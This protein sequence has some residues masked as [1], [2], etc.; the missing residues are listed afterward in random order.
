M[1]FVGWVFDT[2]SIADYTTYLLKNTKA[3]R[4][5]RGTRIAIRRA[6]QSEKGE[7]ESAI[8]QQKIEIQMP[9]STIKPTVSPECL[10]HYPFD[11]HLAVLL[12]AGVLGSPIKC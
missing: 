3:I 9:D 2:Q 4:H 8:A 12:A 11:A 1:E 10:T 7:R 5:R 6:L